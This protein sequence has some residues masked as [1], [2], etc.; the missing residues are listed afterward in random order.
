MRLS[1][2][3]YKQQS[4]SDGYLSQRFDDDDYDVRHRGYN[5]LH[6]QHRYRISFQVSKNIMRE[7][8]KLVNIFQ[9]KKRMFLSP[10]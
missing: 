2:P 6:D 9:H 3:Q 7:L 8:G 10:S 4:R 1:A 5:I